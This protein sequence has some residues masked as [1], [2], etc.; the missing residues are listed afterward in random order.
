MT[1]IAMANGWANRFLWAF[2]SRSKC[3][4]NGGRVVDITPIAARFRAAVENARTVGELKRDEG[5][6][7]IWDHVYADLSEGRPASSA[8]SRGAPNNSRQPFDCLPQPEADPRRRG[9]AGRPIP[10]R[11]KI[12][13]KPGLALH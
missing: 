5:A 13:K 9:R 8:Q 2:A 7:A 10:T 6:C 12:R 4:P 3:L 1:E 11:R